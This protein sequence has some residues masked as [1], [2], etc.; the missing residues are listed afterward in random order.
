[1]G[2]I[3]RQS[4]KA[5][6]FSYVG[7]L[8]GFVNVLFLY[9]KFLGQE[10]IG[11]VE[12][13]R[14]L[15]LL[16]SPFAVFGIT[17]AII[18]FFPVHSEENKDNGFYLS[19]GLILFAWATIFIGIFYLFEE[20]LFD[21][22]GYSTNSLSEYVWLIYPSLGCWILFQYLSLISTSALRI[23][24]PRMLDGIFLRAIATGLIILFG[25]GYISLKTFIVV[26]AIS[27]LF[28]SLV[29]LYYLM[30][31]KIIALKV[32]KTLF[33]KGKFAPIFKYARYVVFGS[34]SSLIIQKVDVVMIGVEEDLMSVGIY[35]IAFYIGSVIEI[36]KRNISDISF[37]ILSKAFEE[38]NNALIEDVYK[39]SSLNQ[40]IVGVFI[41]II[42]W[43][44]L[45]NV[46]QIMP[47]GESYRAGKYVVLFIGVAKLFDMIMGVNH[48]II[49]SSSYYRFNLYINIFLSVMVIVFNL[50]F[51]PIFSITGAA[52][53]SMLAVLCYNV[54]S[55]FVV[56]KIFKIQPLSKQ[57]T[58]LLALVIPI[59]VLGIYLPD[60][61]LPIIS[62]AYKG[63]IL[64][65]LF[66]IGIYFFKI[67][68]QAN[69]L[70]N[71]TLSKV[72][73]KL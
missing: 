12:T 70:I 54:L 50:V 51:I 63:A 67:S 53:A 24:V 6:I 42:V 23:A 18:K 61:S 22:F 28:P 47:D 3:I 21:F 48:Q 69:N 68:E 14:A 58:K 56:W 40:F 52:I 65:L 26:L 33:K 37:P 17:S 44:C 2:V 15:V 35:V 7:I 8:F 27:H 57:T 41:F 43:S 32:D 29:L 16:I 9:P 73:V 31:E 39:K 62:I 49:Q 5:S 10:N 38:K 45:D 30:K 19:L 36:P 46:F 13:I 72:G 59:F 55:F 20:P 1:M 25:L 60:L 11:I 71:T 34:I 66:V 4:I 64:T